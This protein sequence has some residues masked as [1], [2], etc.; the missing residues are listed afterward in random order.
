MEVGLLHMNSVT[1]N[2]GCGVVLKCEVGVE[3]AALLGEHTCFG[4][5]P[6]WL[7]SFMLSNGPP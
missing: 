4:I 2:T 7:T 1:L 6:S 3:E 5:R